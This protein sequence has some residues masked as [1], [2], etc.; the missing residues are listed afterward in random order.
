VKQALH[1][2]PLKQNFTMYSD[3]AFYNFRAGRESSR[4]LY[5]LLAPYG[6]KMMHIMGDTDAILSLAGAWKW[7][8]KLPYPVTRKWTPWVI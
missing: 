7:I 2:N 3:P 4:W 5:E 8:K 6:Y 1:V